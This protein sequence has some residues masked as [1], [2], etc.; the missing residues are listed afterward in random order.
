MKPLTTLKT[1]PKVD[2]LLLLFHCFFYDLL[3][4]SI[5]GN[6]AHCRSADDEHDSSLGFI[7]DLVIKSSGAHRFALYSVW[8]VGYIPALA[9]PLDF[10]HNRFFVV[11]IIRL[12]FK[13]DFHSL[14]HELCSVVMTAACDCKIHFFH[15]C[16]HLSICL[17][18]RFFMLRSYYRSQCPII[19]SMI[20]I[21]KK[22]YASLHNPLTIICIILL[23]K[24]QDKNRWHFLPYHPFLIFL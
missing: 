23:I 8:A 11:W 22:D 14:F 9:E 4:H 5:V 20:S 21:T 7:A 17:F 15:N 16:V 13:L 19:R 12:L 10:D 18:L 3:L 6:P 2:R 1:A 24:L